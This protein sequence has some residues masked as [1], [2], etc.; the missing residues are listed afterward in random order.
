MVGG[1]ITINVNAPVTGV[2]NLKATIIEAVNEATA[3]QNRLA[4]YNLL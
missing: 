3:R 2:D 4:N 1:G